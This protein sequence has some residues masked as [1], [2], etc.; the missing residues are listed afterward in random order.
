VL[1]LRQQVS[2][3]HPT[4]RSAPPL[5]V[6]LKWATAGSIGPAWNRAQNRAGAHAR[7]CARSAGPALRA[8]GAPVATRGG[9]GG[10]LTA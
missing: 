1:E 7:F 10:P 5:Y 8:L 3:G 6:V 2:Y 4:Q 9:G